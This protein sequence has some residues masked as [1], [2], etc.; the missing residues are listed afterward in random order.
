MW[1]RQHVHILLSWHAIAASRTPLAP[2]RQGKRMASVYLE[3]E[4]LR[5]L[6][7]IALDEETTVQSL[8]VEGVNAVFAARG[9]SRIA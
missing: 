6:R 9:Q 8:L 3:P 7:R 2:S 4:A 1:T 5:Q